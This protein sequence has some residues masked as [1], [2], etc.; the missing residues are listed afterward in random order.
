MRR[1]DRIAVLD[2]RAALDRRAVRTHT[3][4]TGPSGREL[5]PPFPLTSMI[6]SVRNQRCNCYG[7]HLI[8]EVAGRG[9]SSMVGIRHVDADE[10]CSLPSLSTA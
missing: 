1:R 3:R 4:A 6:K 9:H 7:A 10:V 2:R 8:I 5:R